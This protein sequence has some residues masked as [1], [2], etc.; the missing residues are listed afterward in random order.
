MAT[1]ENEH[2]DIDTDSPPGR[3]LR[4]IP[5][6][7]PSSISEGDHILYRIN[8]SDEYR[9]MYRSALVENMSDGNITT[10]VNTPCGV[11]RQTQQFTGFKSL[12]KVDYTSESYFGETAVENAKERLGECHYHGLF[13]N[14]HHFASKAKT[15]LEYSLAELVHGIESK[16][17][18]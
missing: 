10:I 4:T 9:P 11:Q 6:D 15:G 14:S 2:L 17:Y 8:S 16:Y 7:R 18:Y 3:P 1:P 13:N 12:H 5:V